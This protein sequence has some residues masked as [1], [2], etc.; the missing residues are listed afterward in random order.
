MVFSHCYSFFHLFCMAS[1]CSF[2]QQFIAQSHEI[3]D[4]SFIFKARLRTP[5]R[6]QIQFALRIYFDETLRTNHH[7]RMSDNNT[8]SLT[9]LPIELIYRILDHLSPKHIL[10]SVRNVCERLNSITDVYHPY[11]VNFASNFF[12]D[13]HQF[14]RKVSFRNQACVIPSIGEGAIL[15]SFGKGI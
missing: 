13:F 6:A 12:L 2:S 3:I 10:L 4:F 11:Q 7:D 5:R 8:A 14:R 9:A 15:F 1:S